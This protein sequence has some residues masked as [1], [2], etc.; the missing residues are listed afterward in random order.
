[1]PHDSGSRH[2]R[3]RERQ[4]RAVQA[5]MNQQERTTRTG[6]F[7]LSVLAAVAFIG[8]GVCLVNL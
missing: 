4:I 1:M 7:W 5:Q 8:L 6:L 2:E 3:E